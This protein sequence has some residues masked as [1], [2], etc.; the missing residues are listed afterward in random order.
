[1]FPQSLPGI[2]IGDVTVSLGK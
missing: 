2:I 1:M